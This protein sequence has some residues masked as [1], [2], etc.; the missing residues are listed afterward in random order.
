MSDTKN[1]VINIDGLDEAFTV[2][3]LGANRRPI[4]LA[5]ALE[6]ATVFLVTR[7]LDTSSCGRYGVASTSKNH[8]FSIEDKEI[9]MIS[10]H[11]TP[12]LLSFA[13][14]VIDEDGE[15]DGK[16]AHLYFMTS[17]SDGEFHW[18]SITMNAVEAEAQ[19]A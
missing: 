4:N 6:E 8:G 18:V 5:S 3:V 12:A 16:T 14:R 15:E 2:A 19:C 1:I 7:F 13:D 17:T 10:R 11:I 9:A